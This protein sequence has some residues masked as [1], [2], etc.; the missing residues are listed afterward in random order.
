MI[1][2]AERVVMSCNQRGTAERWINEGKNAVRYV[3]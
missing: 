2:P 3:R 1:R